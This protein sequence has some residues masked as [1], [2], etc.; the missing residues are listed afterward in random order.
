[1]LAL[2]DDLLALKNKKYV[3]C[4]S[5]VF[6][7]TGYDR[8]GIVF[9]FDFH[10][11]S[12]KV[13]F[14]LKLFMQKC[15]CEVN[16]FASCEIHLN[17]VSFYIGCLFEDRSLLI[18]WFEEWV[19]NDLLSHI[20]HSFVYSFQSK[21]KIMAQCGLLTIIQLTYLHSCLISRASPDCCKLTMN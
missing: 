19:G 5:S 4:F 15:W 16:G 20:H 1:M 14:I 17:N 18:L 8:E 7:K 12:F 11:S 13:I 6:W 3:C 21:W 2:K 10:L 9:L